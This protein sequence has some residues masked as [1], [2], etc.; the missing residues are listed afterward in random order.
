MCYPWE[1]LLIRS[2]REKGRYNHLIT[3][4]QSNLQLPLFQMPEY[5]IYLSIHVAF[6][7]NL[8]VCIPLVNDP[9]MTVISRGNNF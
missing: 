8:L 7:S 5:L 2:R 4:H 9:Y 6:F 3:L 1:K